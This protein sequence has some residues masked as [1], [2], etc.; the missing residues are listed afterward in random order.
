M[1]KELTRRRPVEAIAQRTTAGLDCERRVRKALTK[2]AKTGAP[3]TVEDVCNLAG[4][5]KTFIYDKRRPE[6]TKAVLAARDASQYTKAEQAGRD[7]DNDAASWR[8]R[9]TNAEALVKSLRTTIRERDDRIS[10]LTGQLFDPEGN[11]L[12]EHN[13]ELRRLLG[14]LSDSLR[15]AEVENDTLRRSLTGARANITRERERNISVLMD[16]RS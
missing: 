8:E 1:T 3:F 10:D 11:H 13:A 4:V 5:G 14:T 6:L 15:K 7:G 12:A 2:L 16:H 9:A